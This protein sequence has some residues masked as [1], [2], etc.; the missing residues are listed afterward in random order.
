M[1]AALI[2]A[3][4][5]GVHRLTHPLPFALDHVHTYAL[6]DDEGW[7]IIDAGHLWEAEERW[8]EALA[9]LG[10]PH[11]ARIVITHHHPDHLAGSGALQRV[12]GAPLVQGRI[13]RAV[14]EHLYTGGRFEGIVPPEPAQLLDE[15]EVLDIGSRRFRIFH[16]PGHADGH[17]TLY[18]EEQGHLFGGDVILHRI[19][20]NVSWW[21]GMQPDP[22]ALYQRTLER[23]EELAPAL[24]YPGHH[25]L[26]TDAAARAAEIRAHHEERLDET[27]RHLREGARTPADVL[28]AIWGRKL[29]THEQRFAYGE[30]VSHLQR[31]QGLGRAAE[32][33]PDHWQATAA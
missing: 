29:T 18:D 21:P 22:L 12:T 10:R 1:E 4:G 32:L 3:L 25:G 5:C 33:A 19:T 13:D 8:R 31:L 28:L 27:E 2:E 23:L 11:I 6:E 14:T 17:I 20:P 16:M 30:A 24:V 7:T 26:I 9:R 15:D